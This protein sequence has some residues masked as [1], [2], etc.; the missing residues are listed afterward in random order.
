MTSNKYYKQFVYRIEKKITV[1]DFPKIKDYAKNNIYLYIIHDIIDNN[2]FLYISSKHFEENTKINPITFNLFSLNNNESIFLEK[3]ENKFGDKYFIITEDKTKYSIIFKDII[4]TKNK[5]NKFFKK[6]KTHTKK[7]AVDYPNWYMDKIKEIE[8]KNHSKKVIRELLYKNEYSQEII[9]HCISTFF[10]LKNPEYQKFND[11]SIVM[12]EGKTGKSSLIGYMGEKLDNIS[13]AGLYGS[14]DTLRGKFKGGVVTTTKN[15]ILIDEINE[16]SKNNKGEK[17]LSVLNSLLE[18]GVYNYQKQFGQKITAGNQFM[19]MGNLSN[20]FNLPM[21]LESTF[22]N[23]ETLGRRIGIITY[24]NN[25]N[26]YKMGLIR[27]QTPSDYLLTMQMLL[28]NIFNSILLNPKLI[29]KLYKHKKYHEI[30][31]KYKH[32]LSLLCDTV[33]DETTKSFIRSHSA[34]ID[35]IF[36]RALKLWIFYN[37]DGFL[38]NTKCYDNHTINEV[39]ELTRLEIDKNLVNFKNIKEHIVDFDIK[40]SRKDM[41]IVI[42][43]SLTKKNRKILNFFNI[44]KDI[45]DIKG[46]SHNDLKDKSIIKYIVRDYKQYGIPDNQKTFMLSYGINVSIKNNE[47]YFRFINKNL[48]EDKIKGLFE[49]KTCK[50]LQQID[51]VEDNKKVKESKDNGLDVDDELF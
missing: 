49:N 6:F 23:I 22:G 13:V 36:T 12:D 33:D 47:I 28:S 2:R 40:E 1:E 42:F 14:S 9:N 24:N 31:K 3:K 26:G 37:I 29:E 32:D 21:F 20:K 8:C 5:D 18:N 51:K 27:P 17:I 19:F 11:H 50:E 34:S 10:I 39:L 46:V 41:N 4:Y 43:N 15:T 48:F 44:N 25:L 30:A 45:I 7:V 35:R 38:N 16:L